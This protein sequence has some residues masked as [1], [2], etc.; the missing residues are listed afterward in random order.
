MPEYAY[1]SIPILR[2]LP[3][4]DPDDI[5]G[6]SDTVVAFLNA[7]DAGAARAAIG[8]GTGDGAGS[9]DWADITGKPA[10]IAAGD[11]Q[12]AART[13]I[14][15]VDMAAVTAAVN[16]VINGAPGALD[17]LNELAAAL[18]NDANFAA[19]IAAALGLRV[20]TSR[21]VGTSGSLTGGGDLTADRTLAL[22]N[23]SATP[24]NSKY[25]GTNG[26]GTKGFYDLPTPGGG[27]GVTDGDK[28]DITVSSSG[29][30]WTVDSGL[31]ADKL[32]DGSTNKAYTATEKTKLGGVQSGA[33]A[34]A[35]DAQLRDRATHTG[36]QSADSLTDG[37]SI[38]AFLAAERTKLA[39]VAAGATANS[40]DATLLAR[41]NHTGTQS[42]D[43]ITD[44]TT[45]KA[46]TA[47]EKT[48]LG[49]ISGT[50]TGDQTS[51]S[52]NAGTATKLATARNINGV[53]FDGTADIT[54]SGGGGSNGY[55]QM[56][57]AIS[58]DG[59][60]TITHNLN[61]LFVR[62]T[63]I[64]SYLQN[65]GLT[66][67]NP[68]EEI[69][70][71]WSSAGPNAIIVQPTDAWAANEF[72]I[73]VALTP[74]SG[75]DTTGP[76]AGTLTSPTQ[77]ITTVDLTLTGGTD[78]G[79]GLGGVNWYRSPSGA[80]TPVLVNTN[81]GNTYQDTGLTQ[82]T[83]YDYTAKRFDLLGTLGTASVVLPVT[84]AVPA[85]VARV[86]TPVNN[87]IAAPG[88]AA[89][90]TA[91]IT[92]S[93][94]WASASNGLGLA[95]FS[96]SHSEWVNSSG[97]TILDCVGSVNGAFSQMALEA[98]TPN[99]DV[100]Y[101]I[102]QPSGGVHVF[103][104]KSPIAG[105]ETLTLRVQKSTATTITPSNLIVSTDQ[106]SGVDQ[107]TPFGTPVIDN[108]GGSNGSL[109]IAS[110]V[111]DYTVAVWG[112]HN[113]AGAVTSGMYN[114]TLVPG[115]ILGGTGGAGYNV[116]F[117][118]GVAAGVAGN[119]THSVANN[120]AHGG[121]GFNIRKATS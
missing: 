71:K 49:A 90:A 62:P 45:N 7:G 2:P 102:P 47:T 57:G 108:A 59:Q 120:A 35:S 100:G 72:F 91:T 92:V 42:A 112:Y 46:Y 106:F 43:T 73:Y 61:S 70:F 37:T 116:Y 97:Y 36:T 52:G 93:V 48:K 95:I 39:G 68:G 8:A 9:S 103:Y 29:S 19:T 121:V 63:I 31:S 101:T 24:G 32:V 28:G 41:A 98:L 82:G 117:V 10:V 3:G 64:R 113:G 74:I 33:T 83:T 107:T 60:A 34:N 53:P 15:A 12:A 80:G 16:G 67:A 1:L 119:V 30:V 6:L 85:A 14:G 77:G 13:A 88:V 118:H 99:T 50:N 109:V 55:F 17:T 69:G 27:T 81:G 22:V 18:G 56:V 66:T 58:A 44:G 4:I 86:G 104:K 11:T 114:Q 78:A 26:G 84:T 23:D 65:G 38:K 89:G 115:A 96:E 76:T 111:N 21:Q 94:T 25:Y 5:T 51:V 87:R 75:A 20:Q 54:I 105:A 40:P 79:V 110:N